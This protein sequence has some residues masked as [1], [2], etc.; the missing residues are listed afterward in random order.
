M[1][2]FQKLRTQ[3]AQ[4]HSQLVLGL[5]PSKNQMN[6]E[7]IKKV[8]DDCAPHIV[9]IKPNLAFYEEYHRHILSDIMIYTAQYHPNLVRILDVKRGDIGNTQKRWADADIHNFR[10]DIVTINSYMGQTDTIIPYLKADPNIGVFALA[11]TSNNDTR[12][13]NMYSEG[14]Q[15][16]RH[17]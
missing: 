14:L 12:I 10:P 7:E 11:S 3:T 4:K 17:I 15:I 9:G 5:D 8:I 13:Q 2:A 6:L 16:F 1:H